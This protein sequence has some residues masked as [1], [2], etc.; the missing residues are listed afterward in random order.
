[1]TSE[2]RVPSL[3]QLESGEY[4]GLELTGDFNPQRPNMLAAIWVVAKHLD[5]G[6]RRGIC[7]AM[8]VLVNF[9]VAGFK[10]QP[11]MDSGV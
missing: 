3:H 1:M 11:C 6:F 4:A 10:S 7:P 8:L 5:A 2:K 9:A